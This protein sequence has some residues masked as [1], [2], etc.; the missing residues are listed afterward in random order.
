ML[1]DTV[2]T[3][4]AIIIGR[5]SWKTRGGDIGEHHDEREGLDVTFYTFEGGALR[6]SFP[7]IS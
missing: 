3:D 7:L 5:G 4:C 1:N 6:F 2:I